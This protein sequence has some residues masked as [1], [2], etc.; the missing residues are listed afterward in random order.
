MSF[1]SPYF[2]TWPNLK[3][4]LL[5]FSTEGIVVVGMTLIL[6]VGGFDLSVG[7]VMCLAMVVGGKLFTMGAR[8]A[9]VY[10]IALDANTGKE[11][12]TTEVAALIRNGW[13]DGIEFGAA[14]CRRCGRF[15]F[16]NGCIRGGWGRGASWRFTCR[17][18]W[19]IAG[20]TWSCMARNPH[21]LRRTGLQPCSCSAVQNCRPVQR[22]WA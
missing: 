5:S 13:G 14:G 20:R 22:D 17:P 1:V 8:D 16:G 3:A 15:F 2:F 10:L 21:A 11:L 7:S 4:I 18:R 19:S 12:W 6:V 9:M